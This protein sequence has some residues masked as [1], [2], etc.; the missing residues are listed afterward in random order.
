M[1]K[2]YFLNQVPQVPTDIHLSS[3]SFYLL[4]ERVMIHHWAWKLL[5]YVP[6]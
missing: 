2:N 5:H 3:T 4:F 6:H 1:R